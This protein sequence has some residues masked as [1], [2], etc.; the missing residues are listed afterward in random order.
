M[1]LFF[2]LMALDG[3]EQAVKVLTKVINIDENFAEGHYWLGRINYIQ[4]RFEVAA[5]SFFSAVSLAPEWSSAYAE[6]GLCYFRMHKYTEA[7]K[8]F[9]EAFRLSSSTVNYSFQCPTPNFS[10]SDERWESKVS[11][12]S[13]A[14]MLHYLGL[15]SFERGLFEKS[16]EYYLKGIKLDPDFADFS[17]EIGLAYIFWH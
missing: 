12:L 15:I 8:A 11:S 7:E 10:S 13:P 9:L 17:Q 14:N 2:A 1:N 3:Y 5:P 16:E 4:E 6:L